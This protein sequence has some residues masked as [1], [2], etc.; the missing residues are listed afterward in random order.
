M[1]AVGGSTGKDK[2][3]FNSDSSGGEQEV[4]LDGQSLGTFSSIT[5]LL[6][7]GQAGDDNIQVAGGDDVSAWLY[8]DAGNDRLKGGAGN[9]VILGGVGNDLI[10]GGQGRDLLIGGTGADRIVGNAEDDLLISGYTSFDYDSYGR[11]RSNHEQA[12][13]EIMREW[14]SSRSYGI[15]IANLTNGSGAPIVKTPT[16]FYMPIKPFS[17]M[18]TRMC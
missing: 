5:R 10:V 6:A 18:M 4:S 16:H 11:L 15:R 17:M 1:L 7:F 12:I 8:G 14:T 3:H 9:D 13:S 2:I